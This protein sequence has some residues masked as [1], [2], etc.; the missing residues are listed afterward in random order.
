MA[1]AECAA[2]STIRDSHDRWLQCLVRPIFC[3]PIL[4]SVHLMFRLIFSFLGLFNI[5]KTAEH[6]S[7]KPDYN[8]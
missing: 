1:G 8:G 7:E 5:D 6:H 2:R 3:I 4:Y